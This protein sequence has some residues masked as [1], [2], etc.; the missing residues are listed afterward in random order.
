[1]LPGDAIL[2]E[3]RPPGVGGPAGPSGASGSP[4]PQAPGAARINWQL[5]ATGTGPSVTVGGYTYSTGCTVTPNSGTFVVTTTLLVTFPANPPKVNFYG[6]TEVQQNDGATLTPTPL[7][8][9]LTTTSQSFPTPANNQLIRQYTFVT[10]ADSA[11]N[12]QQLNLRLTAN[13]LASLATGEARCM[14]EGTIVPTT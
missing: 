12:V 8:L 5:S 3:R 2:S 13:G 9:H 4:G 10:L 11:G 1:M 7:N 6:F 14:V